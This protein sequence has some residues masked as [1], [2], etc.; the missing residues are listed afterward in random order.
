MILLILTT[1]VLIAL[2]S[3]RLLVSDISKRI[4]TMYG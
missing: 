2:S 1:D 4:Y 3:V